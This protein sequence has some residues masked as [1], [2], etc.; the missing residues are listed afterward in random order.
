MT[1]RQF[2]HLT[3]I[4]IEINEPQQVGEWNSLST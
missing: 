2:V 1:T 3:R 4:L